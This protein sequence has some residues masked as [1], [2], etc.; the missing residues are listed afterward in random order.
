[1]SVDDIDTSIYTHIHFAFATITKGDFQVDIGD[2]QVKEQFEIFKQMTGIK[3]II[4]FGGWE[5]STAPGTFSI[6]REAVLPA[7]R[8][9]FKT[10]LVNFL[11]KHNLDGIGLDWEYPGV[12]DPPSICRARPGRTNASIYRLLIFLASPPTTLRMV[13][14]ITNFF[15]ASKHP[16]AL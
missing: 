9:K 6:L 1:M 2:D 10:N 14:T 7:N 13:S 16:W 3:K 4:S 5:F 15:P 8:D 11:I 12:S